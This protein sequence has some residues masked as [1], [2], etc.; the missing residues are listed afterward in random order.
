MV[1]NYLPD[2]ECKVTSSL[3]FFWKWH[4]PFSYIRRL[5]ERYSRVIRQCQSCDVFCW[6]WQFGTHS[7]REV[8]EASKTSGDGGCFVFALLF[9]R[10]SLFPSKRIRPMKT[11]YCL[12]T[13]FSAECSCQRHPGPKQQRT[14]HKPNPVLQHIL[15]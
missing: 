3:E 4:R 1:E 5:T 12:P 2:V 11:V 15:C 10:V 8:V 9:Q 14:A 13:Q 6:I 7:I